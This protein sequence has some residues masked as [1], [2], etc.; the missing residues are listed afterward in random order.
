MVSPSASG[1]CP[2]QAN[3][4]LRACECLTQNRTLTK[5]C[6]PHNLELSKCNATT[7]CGDSCSLIDVA[8][9]EGFHCTHDR[10]CTSGMCRENVCV[11]CRDGRLNGLESD[12]DCGGIDCPSCS[13]GKNCTRDQDCSTGLCW[14]GQCSGCGDG[15][16]NGQE[17]CVDGGGSMCILQGQLCEV[18]EGCSTAND[19]AHLLTCISNVCVDNGEEP[20]C[21]QGHAKACPVGKACEASLDC[22]TKQCISGLCAAKNA[23]SLPESCS[24]SEF[25]VNETCVDGGGVCGGWNKL[26]GVGSVVGDNN[27]ADCSSG[28][29]HGGEC[30]ADYAI[31]SCF[32]GK[33]N[34]AETDV[35]CGG[36]C[37]AC[38]HGKSCAQHKDCTSKVCSLGQCVSCNDG[39]AN[40]AES[41][42][43]C[44]GN[45]C[46]KR[47]EAGQRCGSDADCLSSI[48]EDNRCAKLNMLVSINCIDNGLADP[49][50]TDIDCGGECVFV[51]KPC[52]EALRCVR[53]RDCGEDMVCVNS[54]CTLAQRSSRFHLVS[55]T[56]ACENDCAASAHL[57]FLPDSTIEVQGRCSTTHKALVAI[58]STRAA[59]A[60]CGDPLCM[61]S[62]Q[63][64]SMSTW[65]NISVLDIPA[66]VSLTR[67]NSSAVVATGLVEEI[68][69]L[70][71][72]IVVC[73][74]RSLRVL[75]DYAVHVEAIDHFGVSGVC[76][77]LREETK[78]T[79][80]TLLSPYA[81][82]L[83]VQVQWRSLGLRC[84][85]GDAVA[86]IWVQPQCWRWHATG[87]C[88]AFE[89][90]AILNMTN[91]WE[92]I[93]VPVDFRLLIGSHV[94]LKIVEGAKMLAQYIE[95]VFTDKV[96]FQD[97]A[98][99]CVAT[100][101][102]NVSA[103]LSP[104]P[105]MSP[106]ASPSS[107]PIVTTL[108]P[109]T[110]INS[111]TPIPTTLSP[112][113]SPTGSPIVTTSPTGS[114]IG[115]SSTANPSTLRPTSSPTVSPIE[116]TSPTGSP[117]WTSSPSTDRPSGSPTTRPSTSPSIEG[118]DDV[119]IRVEVYVS[120][121]GGP[122]VSSDEGGR[123]NGSLATAVRL[124]I[125]NEST[126][127]VTSDSMCY[128]PQGKSSVRFV[129]VGDE[130][131]WDP[132]SL[133]LDCTTNGC[134]CMDRGSC[135]WV[136]GRLVVYARAELKEGEIR[137]CLSW[138][139][140]NVRDL[141]LVAGFQ[142]GDG[143]AC[144]V[145]TVSR[146]CGNASLLQWNDD[147]FAD[148]KEGLLIDTVYRT[149]Y[150]LSVR[151]YAEDAATESS[152]LVLTID[153]FGIQ[154]P[155][156]FTLPTSAEFYDSWPEGGIE[157]SGMFRNSSRYLRMVCIDVR[158]D[159][160]Q[161][162]D[163]SRFSKTE[164]DPMEI[165]QAEFPSCDAS[166]EFPTLQELVESTPT[167]TPTLDRVG[168]GTGIVGSTRTTELS[169]D[170]IRTN[171][172]GELSGRIILVEEAYNVATSWGV[173][174]AD[175]EAALG[176]CPRAVRL[177]MAE[178][179]CSSSFSDP[180]FIPSAT[181][182]A[183]SWLCMEEEAVV[184][185]A[186]R[187][188]CSENN[189]YVW[190]GS[191]CGLAGGGIGRRLAVNRLA[192][193]EADCK[194]SYAGERCWHDG[195]KRK[196]CKESWERRGVF[197]NGSFV[198][199]MALCDMCADDEDCRLYVYQGVYPRDSAV[200]EYDGALVPGD[201]EP[202]VCRESGISCGDSWNMT[203]Q[204][205]ILK[206]RVFDIYHVREWVWR[207]CNVG[208]RMGSARQPVASV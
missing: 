160:A 2:N 22:Q 88:N 78:I 1:Y 24:N 168:S 173:A 74:H 10:D 140:S 102:L 42:V 17:T 37:I 159:T 3:N 14:E 146:T 169:L 117:T 139:V 118:V 157:T 77:F 80:S 188:M 54:E 60:F 208:H 38:G 58:N 98:F 73:E 20:P 166:V 176:V 72:S 175:L 122:P 62:V 124:I 43:D 135:S 164:V 206:S 84:N 83:T 190:T 184:S 40:G 153:G 150:T 31:E 186:R 48:C 56:T 93:V 91:T 194:E 94:S 167:A 179:I 34:G 170:L 95:R 125:R 202:G 97:I 178:E 64:S 165:C 205:G 21:G 76:S 105:S 162:R 90:V 23:S 189:E 29:A 154:P 138:D 192:C 183:F 99:P 7:T 182:P 163:V 144:K 86:E 18:G 145:S 199:T 174:V 50:E 81:L 101:V 198:N 156:S 49:W 41:D 85:T 9:G 128:L 87:G 45:D 65:I 177:E 195:K 33:M 51:G 141:D 152:G 89:R 44:G 171:A 136:D 36:V 30:V 196:S 26:C 109:S 180:L 127:D 131:K 200:Y 191:S 181:F 53:H 121:C 5:V 59:G 155:L 19:C 27:N 204:V 52:G 57:Q 197:R 75:G 55:G 148:G 71:R 106:T 4:S 92:R 111:S 63:V 130:A 185:S 137:A 28:I 32:D 47:C 66:K 112:T 133:D 35:D 103:P 115:N 68:N 120:L 142:V 143:Q 96:N 161:V 158:M 132:V 114:P 46:A 61:I 70:L 193:G 129:A 39:V 134:V 151:N 25:D 107:S 123:L 110:L 207:V 79:F 67:L 172:S 201:K 113:P 16:Q 119:G 203:V 6:Q 12:I 147:A 8:C 149:V 116:S 13:I 126:C 100:Q 11:S 108:Q 104:A 15:I 69:V 82:P 187:E